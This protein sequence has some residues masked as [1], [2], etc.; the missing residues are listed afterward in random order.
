MPYKQ[1][2]LKLADYQD[3]LVQKL[4]VSNTLIEL[5]SLYH[6]F[7]TDFYGIYHNINKH[8]K[9]SS[10]QTKKYALILGAGATSI[11]SCFV[12]MKLNIIPIIYNRS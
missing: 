8:L 10:N 4:K 6:A 1:D 12:L 5:N 11:T 9:N 2:I 3:E 7:N